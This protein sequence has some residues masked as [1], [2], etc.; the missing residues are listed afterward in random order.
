[1]AK[2]KLT[3]S[4]IGVDTT[5]EAEAAS[6]LYDFSKKTWVNRAGRLGEP[7]VLVDSFSGARFTRIAQLPPGTI[8]WGNADGLGTKPE[9]ARLAGRY[10][11][12]ATDLVA[13]VADDAA[14]LEAEPAHLKTILKVNTLGQN[15]ARL[16]YIKELASGYVPACA[17]AGVAVINGELAQHGDLM[18]KTDE[19]RFEWDATL[20]W[21]AHESRLLDG[22]AIVAGDY[23][24]GL[25]E[26]GLRCNVLSWCARLCK[27]NTAKSGGTRNLGIS[28]WLI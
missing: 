16:H 15:R 19:F 2:S 20:T 27:L 28:V 17:A 8:E 18:G 26:E 21:Y 4:K 12:V 22:S 9:I 7:R 14:I 23:L 25:R 5:I 6:I 10:D 24:I 13:M 1:M 11:T 3:Y